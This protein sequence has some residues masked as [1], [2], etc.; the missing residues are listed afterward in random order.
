[1]DR[2]SILKAGEPPPKMAVGGGPIVPMRILERG[3]VIARYLGRRL[4]GTRF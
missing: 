2:G 4:K 3:M 1:M